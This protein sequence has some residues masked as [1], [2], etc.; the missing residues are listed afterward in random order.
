MTALDTDGLFIYRAGIS[1][2]LAA[3]GSAMLGP[4]EVPPPWPGENVSRTEEES[5]SSVHSVFDCS[6]EVD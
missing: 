4:D 6:C 1:Q 3:K 2:A 5:I